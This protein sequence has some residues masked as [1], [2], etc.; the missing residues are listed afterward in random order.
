MMQPKK[1][2]NLIGLVLVLASASAARAQPQP[3]QGGPPCPP[4]GPPK[5]DVM[6]AEHA[7]ELGI[8]AATV[9]EIREVVAAAEPELEQLHQA[10]R[11]SV[12]RGDRDAFAQADGALREKMRAVMEQVK[13]LLTAEQWD[14]LRRL[15]PPPPP[16]P[17]DGEGGFPPPP[18]GAMSGAPGGGPG[19]GPF[20]PPPPP[21]LDRIIADRGAEAGVSAAV[22]QA[23]QDLAAAA[24]SEIDDLR[25]AVERAAQGGEPVEFA[26]ALRALHEREDLLLEEILGQLTA[27]QWQAIQKLL[28]PPPPPPPPPPA[29]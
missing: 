5:V 27:A 15:L 16:P 14:A 19:P 17:P 6:V 8:D 7:D 12:Q 10:L 1:T 13:A 9:D 22:V 4:G 18:P 24:R 11:E 2:M 28:P 20:P 23:I 25:R 3:P 26:R 29:Q 21:P